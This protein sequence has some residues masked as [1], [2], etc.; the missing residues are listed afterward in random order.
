MDDLLASLSS[1]IK[2]IEKKDRED[3]KKE[4]SMQKKL[5]AE[6]KN[7]FAALPSQ[8]EASK[9]IHSAIVEGFNKIFSKTDAKKRFLMKK[10]KRK[11]ARKEKR[12]RMIADKMGERRS[13]NLK[14]KK[15]KNRIKAMY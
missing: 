14:K 7:P 5:I 4:I 9:Q 10:A 6:N 15:R 3:T 13:R 12:A 2:D 8:G 11:Q 1:S